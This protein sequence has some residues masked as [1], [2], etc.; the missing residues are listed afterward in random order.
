[1]LFHSKEFLFFFLPIVYIGTVLLTRIKPIAAVL[2]LA[3]ASLVFYAFGEVAEIGITGFEFGHLALILF[4]IIF[5]YQLGKRLS[6]NNRNKKC[7]LVFGITV[8]LLLLGYFKYAD[9]MVSTLYSM[10]GGIFN[11]FGIK[12]PLAISFFTFQQIAFLVDISKGR[13]TIPRFK[14]YLLFVGFFPQLIA[15]PIVKC[16]QIV[17]QL[18]SGNLGRPN[19]AMIWTGLCLFAIGVTKKS[20]FADGIRPLADD[21]FRAVSEGQILSFAEAWCGAVAFGFQVY[22][23]FSAYSDIAIGLGLLFGLKLP[24]NFNSPYQ[25]TSIIDFWRRWH[26]TLSEFL[27]DYLYIPLGGNRRGMV[28]AMAN[29]MIVMLIGGLWHGASW[30][31]MIW[32]GLH[33]ALIA[34]NHLIRSKFSTP[35]FNTIS[36][37]A[38]TQTLFTFFI[39]TLAWTFFRSPDLADSISMVK[40][41]LGFHGIDLPRSIPVSDTGYFRSSGMFSNEVLNKALFPLLVVLGVLSWLAPNSQ[42]IVGMDLTKPCEPNP[43]VPKKKV[44]FYSGCLLFFGLKSTFETVSFDYLYFRF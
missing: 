34:S 1:M 29:V 3:I 11:G 33:G 21:A 28:H 5:N 40:S 27:R 19:Q 2:W 15:G 36:L 14:D 43:K 18:K 6:A 37:R 10:W 9:L 23:D 42:K 32:G 24:I 26:I 20:E 31:F 12:L 16:Q 30:N 17:P 7:K 44:L 4:S 22:F 25:A 13:F 35:E 8:N 38:V 39:V 41:M